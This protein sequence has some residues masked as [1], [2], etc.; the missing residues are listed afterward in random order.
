M[1]MKPPI[2]FA[3]VMLAHCAGAGESSHLKGGLVPLTD[4]RGS[5]VEKALAP[6]RVAL[7]VGVDAFDDSF[8]PPLRFAAK[9]ATDLGR[10]L[11]SRDIG[12]FDDLVVLTKREETTK[13]RVLEEIDRLRTRAPRSEDTVVV[14]VS[15][16]GTLSLSPEGP[17]RVLVLTDTKREALERTGL[18]VNALA[19]RFEHLASR[20]KV[21][22]L[23]TCHSGGGKSLLTPEVERIL[24][25]VK[26]AIAPLSE[27]SRASLVLSAADFG[28]PAREDDRLGNDVYTHYFIE[29][30]SK[31]AD[32]DGD[33]AVSATEAHDYAR[34]RTYEF[35]MGLQTPTI[36]SIIVG[37][38]PVVL[39]GRPTSTPRPI[40]Y[41]YA[42]M[43]DGFAVLVNGRN[44]GVLPGNIALEA[45]TQDVE[46]RKGDASY[47]YDALEVELGDRI[48]AERILR[49][50]DRRF[51]LD[52]G[53]GVFAI[54]DSNLAGR[55][56]RPMAGIN[57]TFR[58]KEALFS[59]LDLA[60]DGGYSISS[61]AIRP[62]DQAVNQTLSALQLGVGTLYPIDLGRGFVRLAAGPHLSY[63]LLRRS[64][65][66][67]DLNE[68]QSFGT[69]MP[70]VMAGATLR[71][72][73]FELAFSSQLHYL[74][75]VLDG[76]THSIASG[77][78]S[79]SGGW[80]F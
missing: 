38:D 12:D 25:G 6:R 1:R 40:L 63:L 67:P 37:T 60:L 51:S 62:V 15:A 4:V 54:L 24:S 39:A 13:A 75:L 49:G 69:L 61:Q 56:V 76:K 50:D 64:L 41:G 70:G 52:I 35:T 18:E 27:V 9:D 74:P 79:L 48:P 26:G 66:L 14:Y 44:K 17:K 43:L 53:G 46:L 11:E 10:A 36:Q 65:N 42:P 57:A 55:V 45:G 34:R 47:S 2:A 23:A 20:R 28:Q 72:G 19:D 71:L 31:G 7:L 30:L 22:I 73:R 33:G 3:W 80:R 32:V 29:A 16:H 77:S 5:D 58:M 21:L 78:L 68:K 59:T 8:W